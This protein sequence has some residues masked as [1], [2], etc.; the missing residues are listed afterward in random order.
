[1]STSTAKRTTTD[2]PTAAR[3]ARLPRGM[4]RAWAWIAA[5][6][7]TLAPAAAIGAQ[8]RSAVGSTERPVVV[9]RV[10]KRIVVQPIIEEVPA[11][12]VVVGGSSSGSASGGTV[13][14]SS[15]PAPAPAPPVSTGGS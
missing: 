12:V 7:G 6:L 13:S 5:T 2:G 15:A 8:P 11:Q 9:R 14:V 3:R 4:L 10:I 1:M